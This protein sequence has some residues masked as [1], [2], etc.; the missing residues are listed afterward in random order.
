[1]E[2]E[3]EVTVSES[4]RIPSAAHLDTVPYGDE[5]PAHLHAKTFLVVF[6]VFCI[7]FA[8]LVNI[9]GA[10]AVRYLSADLLD[11]CY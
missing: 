8:Q 4:K 5:P 1:M 9:V 11:I 2:E 3:Q 6:A 10:G 7:Y